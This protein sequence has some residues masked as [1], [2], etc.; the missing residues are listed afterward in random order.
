MDIEAIKRT[1]DGLDVLDDIYRY[2]CEGFDAIPEDDFERLKWYGLF[3]RKQ[4]PGFFMMRLRM[5]NGFLTSEQLEGI[6]NI[7]LAFC[8]EASCAQENSK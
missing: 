1:K 6:A 3:R 8:D 5:P 2:A 4:T 7:A